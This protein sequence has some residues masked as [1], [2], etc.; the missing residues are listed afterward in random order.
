MALYHRPVRGKREAERRAQPAVG[1]FRS[2]GEVLQDCDDCPEMVV[3]P[4]GSFLMGSPEGE[5]SRSD[6]EG[7][8]HRVAIGEPLAVGK[9]EVTFDER[10]RTA[11]QGSGDL[12]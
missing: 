12:L 9:Y 5:A 11:E 10:H 3:I 2:V 6:D 7:R 8:Q 4:A 1:R